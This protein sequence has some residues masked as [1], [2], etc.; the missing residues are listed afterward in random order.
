MAVAATPKLW[1]FGD[2]R[3]EQAWQSGLAGDLE[4]VIAA[5]G[6]RETLLA[7]GRPYVG[8]LRGPLLAYHLDVA[9]R[10]VGFE[11][12]APGVVFR[13]RLH[14]D[15]SVEP[16]VEGFSLRATAGRWQVRVRCP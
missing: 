15:S 14:R 6:G 9:K 4:R 3:R 7:C 8:N 10:R 12:A 13:S 1:G 2:L 5:A 16:V 11:P